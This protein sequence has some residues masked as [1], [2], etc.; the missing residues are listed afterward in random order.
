MNQGLFG[1][2][3]Q[4]PTTLL[5]VHIP[6][7]RQLLQEATN[8]CRIDPSRYITALGRDAVHGFRTTPLKEYPPAF[9]KF[10]SKLFQDTWSTMLPIKTDESI[11]HKQLERFFTKIDSTLTMGKDYAKEANETDNHYEDLEL[12]HVKEEPVT[13]TEDA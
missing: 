1:A 10:I 4:K 12:N 13:P 2:R 5:C 6:R 11:M 3:S 9:C 7:A 8:Q